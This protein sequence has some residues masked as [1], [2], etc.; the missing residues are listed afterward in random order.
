MP[1]WVAVKPAPSGIDRTSQV[2]MSLPRPSSD[3]SNTRMPFST[4][5]PGPPDCATCRTCARVGPVNVTAV[6]ERRVIDS[7]ST[8][9]EQI[10]YARA[11]VV[12]DRVFVSGTTGFDY[13]TMTIPEGVVGQAEQ[14]LLNVA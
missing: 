1:T 10:G 11:V 12:G 2:R 3:F 6:G 14:A 5:T 4:G 7:G 13:E 8:F 9:E